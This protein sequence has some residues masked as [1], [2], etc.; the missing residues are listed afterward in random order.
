M[1]FDICFK[2]REKAADAVARNEE[3]ARSLLARFPSLSRFALDFDMI[4]KSIGVPRDKVLSHWCQ[5]EL[6]DDGNELGNAIIT[7]W[8]ESVVVEVPSRPALGIPATLERLAP[9]FGALREVGLETDPEFDVS[10]EY[11]MQKTRVEQVARI[12]GEGG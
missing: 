8:P 9:L 2:W 3:L 1:G 11:E 5:V 6:D 4:A 12:V 10:T 7:F